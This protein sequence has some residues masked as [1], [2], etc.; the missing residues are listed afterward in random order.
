[1]PSPRLGP[2]SADDQKR[3]QEQSAANLI[4]R[5]SLRYESWSQ[6]L[7]EESQLV[8]YALV[9]G[10]NIRVESLTEE[11]HDGIA[12]QGILSLDNL[13]CLLLAHQ[14]TLQLL[15]VAEPVTPEKPKRRIGFYVSSVPTE[16]DDQT[17]LDDQEEGLQEWQ[18]IE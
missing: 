14:S 9:S 11:S 1:L 5:L 3:F 17:E 13:P 10:F 16:S 12:I 18:G 15:C 4:N 7:S 6:E 2:L 8:I